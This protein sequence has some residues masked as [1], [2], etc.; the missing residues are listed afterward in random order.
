MSGT[1]QISIS[2]ATYKAI[3]AQRLSLVENHD[4][5]IRRAL[6]SRSERRTQTMRDIARSCAPVQR[7]RGH[8]EVDL[9]GRVQPVANFKAAYVAI[10]GAL[11]RHKPSLYE[12]IAHEGTSRRR[13]AATSAEGLY[14]ESPHL[15]RDHALQVSDQWYIDTNLSRV[16]I[17]Q[18]LDVAARIAGYRYGED[19]RIIGG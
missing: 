13:W 12:H 5:I 15:A 11:V 4:A 18:R 10:L 19:V 2:L 17:D 7:K 8:V 1:A 6:A 14:V 16:Q 9:F 3:E